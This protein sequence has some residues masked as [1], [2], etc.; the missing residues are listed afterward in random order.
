VPPRCWHPQRWSRWN[1]SRITAIFVLDKGK[2]V[3]VVHVHDLLR[4]A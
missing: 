1:A 3:G 4:R 2:S